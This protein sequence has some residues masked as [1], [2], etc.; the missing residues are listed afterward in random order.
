MNLLFQMDVQEKV[1]FQRVGTKLLLCFALEGS[2]K[3]C[4]ELGKDEVSAL[5][6]DLVGHDL[7]MHYYNL[8]LEEANGFVE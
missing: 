6:D 3:V 2:N 4:L 5:L 8:S 1:Q 7:E